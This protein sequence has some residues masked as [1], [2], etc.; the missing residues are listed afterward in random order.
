VNCGTDCEE[1]GPAPDELGIND[2]E[3]APDELGINDDEPAPDEL[4]TTAD[5]LGTTA[6]ELGMA[7]EEL[8]PAEYPGLMSAE[9]RHDLN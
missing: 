5:E 2:D 6:D 8:G 7:V 3:P 1:L 9:S 4:G